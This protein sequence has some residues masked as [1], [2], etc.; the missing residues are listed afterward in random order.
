MSEQKWEEIV[1]L[2]WHGTP[3]LGLLVGIS[4]ATERWSGLVWR[5]QTVSATAVMARP[6]WQQQPHYSCHDSLSQLAWS[7]HIS[8]TETLEYFHNSKNMNLLYFINSQVLKHSLVSVNLTQDFLPLPCNVPEMVG[9]FSC[10]DV[11]F[12]VSKN[13]RIDANVTQCY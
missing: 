7:I 6:A 3:L 8:A 1:L 9:K 2:G 11:L 4:M 13:I 5:V 12:Y 10:N